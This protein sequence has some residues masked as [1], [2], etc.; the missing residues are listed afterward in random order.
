MDE[1]DQMRERVR[2]VYIW[3]PNPNLGFECNMPLLPVF[4]G[5]ISAIHESSE[6]N[7]KVSITMWYV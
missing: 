5:G 7:S 6:L 4:F 2:R 1:E 3:A